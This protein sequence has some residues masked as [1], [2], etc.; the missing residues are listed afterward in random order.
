M[1]S[2]ATERNSHS[3]GYPGTRVEVIGHIEKWRD[4]QDGL[5][6]PIFWLSGPAGAGKTAIMQ[7][8]AENCKAQGVPQAN[9]FFFRTD[10]SRNA[11]F[12][13]IATLLHQIILLYL[14]M[15]KAVAAVLLSN[16]LI[17]NSILEEQLEKLIVTPLCTI[18]ESSLAYRPPLLLIDGLDECDSNSK[19]DQLKILHAFDKVL[20]AHPSL[21]CLLV[22]SRD[23]SRIKT[24][25]KTMAS[26]FFPLYLDDSYSPASDIWLFVNAQFQKIRKTHSLAHL[27]D[28]TWPAVTDVNEIV[29]KSSGQF[30]YA[31]TVMHFISDS[32]ASPELSLERVRGAAQLATKSPFSFLDAIYTYILSQA[33]DQQ[34]LKDVLH[35]HFWLVE[36]KITL[37]ETLSIL[38]HQYTNSVIHSCIADMTAI[39]WFENK[40]LIFYHA[41]LTKFFHN[42]SRSGEY[43]VD[44][45]MF[46]LKILPLLL[47]HNHYNGGE[48]VMSIYHLQKLKIMTLEIMRATNIMNGLYLGLRIIPLAIFIPLHDLC[49]LNHAVAEYKQFLKMWRYIA[50]WKITCLNRDVLQNP[51]VVVDAL[52][53]ISASNADET[54]EWVGDLLWH[55]QAKVH[56]IDIALGLQIFEMFSFW[57]HYP[58]NLK[59]YKKL[60]IQ[61][62]LWAVSNNILLPDMDNLP[63]YPPTNEITSSSTSGEVTK[64]Y[65]LPCSQRYIMM[66]W[67]KQLH[68]DTTR[69]P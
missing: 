41:S 32:S 68:G 25:F 28:A 12:P 63:D 33:D 5:Q 55:I 24:A 13:L 65:G 4:A 60:V 42:Q 16:P 38:D 64:V 14:L 27:L 1:D 22:A 43:F 21:I 18:Q 46:D 23:K 53:P 52:H 34:A 19:H 39:A 69:D 47:E 37:Q 62:I 58:H 59:E 56:Q 11:L 26:S 48:L 40:K 49:V 54:T 20:A 35:A 8:I 61:W 10:A 67:I 50:M 66:A 29:E 7:T 57:Q 15:E 30:I 9:F 2:L 44:L 36:N 17:L 3:Q 51:Y 31:A 45:D 6:A